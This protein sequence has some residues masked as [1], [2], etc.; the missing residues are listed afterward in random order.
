MNFKIDIK[1]SASQACKIYMEKECQYRIILLL[2]MTKFP[3]ILPMQN[4][5]I[6]VD[7]L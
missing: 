2:Y 6:S 3:T 5:N 1:H 7:E 4:S